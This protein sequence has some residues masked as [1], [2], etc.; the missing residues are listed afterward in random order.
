MSD[1]TS[2]LAALIA[3]LLGGVHCVGMCGGITTALT[4]GSDAKRHGSGLFVL[5]YNGG[6]ILSYTVAGALSGFAGA[7]FGEMVAVQRGQ[8]LLGLAAALFMVVLGLYLGGWWSGLRRVEELGG[9]LWRRIQPLGSRLL[10][11][12]SPLQALL[13]GVVWGWIPCGLV[14]SMLVWS[15]AAGGAVEG[16]LLLF[17]FGVGTLPVMVGMGMVA[18]HLREAITR[19]IVRHLAGGV[20]ILFGLWTLWRTLALAGAVSGPP[21]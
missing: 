20:V 12:R 2:L 14:Y 10:P 19:P 7:A 17:S 6:R 3:G 4:L 1:E 16:A 8:W 13:L 15:L 9:V 18:G 11:V 21:A 5:A